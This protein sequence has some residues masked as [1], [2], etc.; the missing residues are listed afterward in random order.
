MPRLYPNIALKESVSL[1]PMGMD[2]HPPAAHLT[3]HHPPVSVK[4]DFL[5][6]AI[7][8]PS[9]TYILWTT[10]N[11]HLLWTY[12]QSTPTFFLERKV[13]LIREGEFNRY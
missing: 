12:Q 3:S 8:P 7:I 9:P 6:I 10:H 11:P 1:H 5:I 13:A 2:V 4:P